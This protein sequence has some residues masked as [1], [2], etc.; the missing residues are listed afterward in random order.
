MVVNYAFYSLAL[1]ISIIATIFDIKRRIIPNFVPIILIL[2]GLIRI[3]HSLENKELIFDAIAGLILSTA[4][5]LLCKVISRS[6]LGM[7]DVKLIISLG[8]LLGVSN[9]SIV[10][11]VTCVSSFVFGAIQL[12][13]LHKD[14]DSTFPFAPFIT[15]GIAVWMIGYFKEVVF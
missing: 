12:I 8:L 7:G 11:L 5:C 10:L 15:V 1:I 6:G 2:M 14:K 3:L 13:L 4:V 9:M